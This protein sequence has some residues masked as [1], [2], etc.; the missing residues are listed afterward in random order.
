MDPSWSEFDI[1]DE[2]GDD[3]TS[4]FRRKIFETT[5][6]TCGS[7]DFDSFILPVDGACVGPFGLPRP[8]GNF[9][10]IEVAQHGVAETA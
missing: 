1:T 6:G 2:I 10:V 7:T 8:W 3:D 5:N 4:S 9:S